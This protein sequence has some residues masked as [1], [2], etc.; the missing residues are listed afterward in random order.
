MT[1]RLGGLLIALLPVSAFA[2]NFP[3]T[4]LVEYVLECM[5]QQPNKQEY[6]YKCSCVIDEIAKKYKK[7]EEFVEASTAARH[8]S[9]AGDRGGVFR[10]PKEVKN[11]AE[12]FSEIEKQARKTCLIKE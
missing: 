10:D 1:L 12:K 6:L 9:L 8:Q 2:H 5:Y 4:G 7:Y 11:A 3:T